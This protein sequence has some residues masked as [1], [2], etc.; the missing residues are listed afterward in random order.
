MNLDLFASAFPRLYHVAYVDSWPSIKRHGLLSTLGLLDLY[1][2]SD[3]K[4]TAIL[5][6]HRGESITISHRTHGNAV[7]RD[8]KPMSDSAL[9]KC[10]QEGLTPTLW[11]EYLNGFSFLWPTTDRLY[12]FLEAKPYRKQS[13]IV[14][15]LD[16]RA[17]L[18]SIMDRVFISRI[19]S[20][21]TL[22][23]PRPRG[24]DTLEPMARFDLEY[25]LKKRGRTNAV[26]EIA[27][28]YGVGDVMPYLVNVQRVKG[29]EIL[30]QIA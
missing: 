7:I 25:W 6:K 11:Y 19:N 2:V 10:L 14:I 22:F 24:L 18:P 27:V 26:A 15:T 21:S 20:G 23:N 17:L 16:T 12:R 13:H 28:R 5:S 1:E 4:R 30:E 29:R 3:E 9:T 8:Q